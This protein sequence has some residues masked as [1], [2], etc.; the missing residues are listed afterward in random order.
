MISTKIRSLFAIAIF[1]MSLS[2]P[3]AVTPVVGT[4]QIVAVRDCITG[5]T[6][7]RSTT[8]FKTDDDKWFGIYTNYYAATQTNL[9]LQS[10]PA[11]S[12]VMLAFAG[13]H[14]VEVRAS[15]I[16]LTSC[17]ISATYLWNAV[18]DY[19]HVGE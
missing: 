9:S 10:N 17:G 8:L 3:A 18:G 14:E 11:L 12:L 5:A 7:W 19:I 6:A 1:V 13:G 2:T 16:T 4:G 15:F